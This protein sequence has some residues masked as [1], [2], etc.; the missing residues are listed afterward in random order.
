MSLAVPQDTRPANVID[1]PGVMRE[2]GPGFAARAA[3]YDAT[4]TF[5]AENFT[6]LKTHGVFA[7]GVPAELG[8]GGATYAELCAMLRALAY[9]CGSTALTL[10][11]HTHVVATMVWRWRRNPKPVEALLRRIVDERL[12]L[13]TSGASDWLTASGTAEPVDGGWRIKARKIF[14]SGSPYGDLLMTQAVHADPQAGPTVLHFAVPIRQPGVAPQDTWRVLGMRGTGS[15]DVIIDDLFVPDSSIMLRR[16]A[17]QWSPPF[18]LAIG[19]IPLPLVYGVYLGIAEAARDATLALARKRA[20]DPG[21]VHLVGEMENEL[22]AAR[23]AHRDM[24]EAAATGEPGPETTNRIITDRT[25]VGRAVAHVVDKAMDIAGGSSFYRACPLERLF[26]DVQ[27][28]RFHRPQ[29]R[30]QLGFSGRLAL[31][32]DI[33][34]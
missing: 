12:V 33:D 6:D 9:Y 3:H 11:M 10:S 29:E 2:L 32:L 25:L 34:G 17:G 7:A 31:G 5:V 20:A 23:L 15:H 28:A 19:M 30:T 4:D 16:P 13:V 22:A 24:V 8:G 26:R 14:A 18:H 21:L 1:W 27:G